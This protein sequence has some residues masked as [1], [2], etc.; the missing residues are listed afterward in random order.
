M[1]DV[2]SFPP[3]GEPMVTVALAVLNGGEVLEHAVRSVLNQSWPHWE[4]LLLDDGSTD[5]AIDRLPVLTDPR[6]IV[7]RDGQN[8]GLA[9]RLNQAVGMAKGKYF[10][11]MD[12]DD[13]CH[14]ERFARQIAF[15]DSHPEVDLLATQCLTIDEQARLIG[16]LP[17]AINHADICRRPWQGF[18]MAH[19]SWL[20]RTEWFRR[21]GYEDPAPYCCEDQELLL[22][23]HYSSCYHTL[24]TYLLA[25]RIRTHTPWKK[26][27]HTRVSMGK[28]KIRHFLDRQELVNALLSGF[29]ELAR[30]GHDV[31][32]E[33]CHRLS[34]PTKVGNCSIPAQKE[35][36][37]WESLITAIKASAERSNSN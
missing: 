33:I 23:A 35:R 5:E 2:S 37:E 8:L 21:H 16:R 22:R 24:P 13:L 6:I 18:Y 28:M 31:W 10:A 7:I 20:G 32:K 9:S 34:L 25:Y 19:P 15:L 17:S 14:P 4:L 30:A 1:S 27:F 12:H 29:I 3:D 36:Q 11:R 26:Q